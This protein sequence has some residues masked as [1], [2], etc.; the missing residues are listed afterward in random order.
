MRKEGL[1][2]NKSDTYDDVPCDYCGAE[3]GQLCKSAGGYVYRESAHAIR[4]SASLAT[5]EGK[6]FPGKK[7]GSADMTDRLGAALCYIKTA[8]GV[9]QARTLLDYACAVVE[10]MPKAEGRKFE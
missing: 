9:E 1:V 6:D 4:A 10:K 7:T 3:V 2:S 5:R 8:G